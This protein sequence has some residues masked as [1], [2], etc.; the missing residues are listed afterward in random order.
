M[1]I[2]NFEKKKTMLSK[3]ALNLRTFRKT[4]E[5]QWKPRKKKSICN[6]RSQSLLFVLLEFRHHFKGDGKEPVPERFDPSETT[7]SG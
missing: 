4:F 3:Q 1:G 6:K 5:I 7:K 2:L